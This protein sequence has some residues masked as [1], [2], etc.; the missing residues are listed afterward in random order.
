MVHHFI[1]HFYRHFLVNTADRIIRVYN[2]ADVLRAGINGENVEATNKLQDTVN[3]CTWKRCAFSA[4]GE[5]LCA[6]SSR[7]HAIHI[8]ELQSGSLVKILT[9][10]KGEVLLDLLWHPRRPCICSLGNGNSGLVHCWSQTHVESWS[11][12]APSFHELE[13]NQEYNEKESEFDVTDADDTERQRAA[14]PDD[15]QVDEDEEIDIDRNEF[16]YSSDEELDVAQ[17]AEALV[18]IKLAVEIDDPEEVPPKRT[19]EGAG[20]SDT[21]VGGKPTT[22]A[23][24]PVFSPPIASPLFSAPRD[25]SGRGGK[26]SKLTPPAFRPSPPSSKRRRVG[27]SPTRSQAQTYMHEGRSPRHAP[28]SSSSASF[29]ATRPILPSPLLLDGAPSGEAHPIVQHL[30]KEKG[31]NINVASR[32][33]T[34]SASTSRLK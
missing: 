16:Y 29:S 6:G 24:N 21:L 1:E 32:R 27:N 26:P 34:S 18:F 17:R 12:F 20:S 28:G 5:Y 8:W 11:A 4:D 30:R 13:E 10:T 9:G 14:G 2:V 25:V 19:P 15:G 31:V 3:K 22:G 7:L 33:G 23:A